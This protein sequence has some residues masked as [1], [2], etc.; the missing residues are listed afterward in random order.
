MTAQS[1]YVERRLEPQEKWHDKRAKL[2]KRC[3]YTAEVATV[4]AGAA[5]PVVTLWAVKDTW[6]RR[7][8]DNGVSWLTD[9]TFSDVVSPLPAQPDPG[10]Q[11]TYAGDYDYGKPSPNQH[12]RAWVDG[13]VAI[14]GSSQQ[15]AFHDRQSTGA[16]SPTPTPRATAT[17]TAT[18][19]PSPTPTATA[20]AT[21]AQITLT[22]N[23]HKVKGQEIVNL[24]WNGATSSNVD[25]YRD[26]MVIDTVPNNPSSY[27]DST[28][29]RGHGSFI[30]K[31]CNA[32][33]QTCS[34]QVTVSF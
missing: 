8:T 24:T 7:S 11:A 17:P 28:G 21:P 9:Q 2:N 10:I 1:D 23:G 27:T 34:N 15:D 13:R 30:Y 4:L 26:G 3:F 18:V 14:G 32:G 22:A 16:A 29:A 31:V 33:T 19:A 20:T 6:A 5:I 12:L 25:I